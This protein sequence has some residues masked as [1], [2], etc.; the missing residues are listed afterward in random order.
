[1]GV[2]ERILRSSREELCQVPSVQEHKLA[3]L[4]MSMQ[5]DDMQCPR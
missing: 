2:Q 1:M 3:H 4:Q 5:V